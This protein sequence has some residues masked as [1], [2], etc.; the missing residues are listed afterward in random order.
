MSLDVLGLDDDQRLIYERLVR[1]GAMSEREVADRTGMALD[2]VRRLLGRLARR[3]LVAD[4]GLVDHR[5]AAAPP[6]V[7]LGA[8]ILDHEERLRQAQSD[9]LVLGQHYREAASDHRGVID[10][11]RGADAVRQ[12]FNQLQRGARRQVMLFVRGDVVAVST[13]ENVEEEVAMARGVQYR[14]VMERSRLEAPGMLDGVREAVS[15]G[16]QVRVAGS[17]PIRLLVVDEEVAMIPL[18]A[19]GLD[20]SGG[21]LLLHAGGL[22]D[23]AVSLFERTWESATPMTLGADDTVGAGQDVAERELLELLSAGLTDQ[24]IANRLGLSLRTVQRR[25]HALM[26]QVGADSRLQLGV[27]AVRRGW[28]PR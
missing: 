18:V 1:E 9:M 10:V 25:V 26:A 12:R 3:G 16:V 4:D 22:L 15:S 23:M 24:R 13:E 7:A 8:L 17:L 2:Q 11:V 19:A 28:L 14:F 21:A 27:A 6:E 5:Y 20:Q